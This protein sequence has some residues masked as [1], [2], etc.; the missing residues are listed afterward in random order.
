MTRTRS[1]EVDKGTASQVIAPWSLAWCHERCHKQESDALRESIQASVRKAGG[2]L[3]CLKKAQKF[4]TW[5]ASATQ[6]PY[7]L[8]S[9]WREIKPCVQVIAQYATH[10]FPAMI[11]VCLDQ[12]KQYKRVAEWA[13][14]LAQQGFREHVQIIRDLSELSGLLPKMVGST[15][16]GTAAAAAASSP[17][18][19]APAVEASTTLVAQLARL[20]FVAPAPCAA[21]LGREPWSTAAILGTHVAQVELANVELRCLA[22][23]GCRRREVAGEAP[24]SFAACKARVLNRS[25]AQM[26]TH[27]CPSESAAE[28]QRMLISSMPL[29]YE[30]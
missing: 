26:L 19:Q 6:Q 28:V 9:D 3:V 5:V 20:S 2:D 14:T 11:V 17:S 27:I 29:Q 22:S 7:V 10:N 8:L 30:D 25:V 18:L 13:S 1:A 4:A 15:S 16:V 24:R 21:E 12:P 23:E